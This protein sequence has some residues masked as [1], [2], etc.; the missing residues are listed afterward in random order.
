MIHGVSDLVSLF[1]QEDS[2][3]EVNLNL[4]VHFGCQSH[5]AKTGTICWSTNVVPKF[6]HLKCQLYRK[7]TVVYR[8]E[9]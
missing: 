2:D 3:S 7:L 5:I 8:K 4:H 6:S 1:S 9:N